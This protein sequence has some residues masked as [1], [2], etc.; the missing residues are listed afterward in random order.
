MSPKTMS[1]AM[2]PRFAEADMEK[3]LTKKFSKA[4]KDRQN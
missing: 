4:I 1:Y 2:P 3:W